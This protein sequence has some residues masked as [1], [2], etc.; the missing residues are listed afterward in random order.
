M[1]DTSPYKNIN[2][3]DYLLGNKDVAYYKRPIIIDEN[4]LDNKEIKKLMWNQDYNK[5]PDIG[6]IIDMLKDLSD[7][8]HSL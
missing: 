5:R 1:E 4:C 3:N 8:I 6:L 7:Q 2:I